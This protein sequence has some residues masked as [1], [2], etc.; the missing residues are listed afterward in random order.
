[1]KKSDHLLIQQVLDGDI[2]QEAFDSFQ[3]RLREEP[4]L[5][6]LYEQY[7]LLQHTLSEEF[8]GRHMIGIRPKESKRPIVSYSAAI[9]VAAVLTLFAVVWFTRPWDTE[10]TEGDVAALTFSVDAAWRIEG[11]SRSIGGATAVDTGGTLHLECGRAAIWLSPSVSALVEG[12]AEL[13]FQS[14]DKLFMNAGRGYFTI[15]SNGSGL[16]LETP[17]MTSSDHGTEFG[18]EV[19]VDGPDEILVSQGSVQIV[20]KSANESV[21]LVG[22]DAAQIPTTGAI[23]RFAPDGRRF[24]KEM[25]R[26][27]SVSPFDNPTLSESQTNDGVHSNFLRF[28]KPIP[29]PGSSVLLTSVDIGKSSIAGSDANDGA[30][31]IFFSKGNEVLHF[32]DSSDSPANRFLDAKKDAPVIRTQRPI[33]GM[34]M[35]TLRYDPHT[36]DVSLH[37]G[38]LPLGQLICSGKIP[39]GSAFDEIRLGASPDSALA[40]NALEIRVGVD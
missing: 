21:L 5:L 25:G 39:P 9:S 1:M 15:G 26:F 32:A 4:E 23:G 12:P 37:E 11:S 34:H 3:N 2:S 20:S 8:E 28:P 36:G 19:P 14:R 16:T 13:T 22:G 18:I 7:A 6:E 31:M 29:E 35:V 17:R 10:V 40:L 38:G 33:A 30:S 27:R 24:A